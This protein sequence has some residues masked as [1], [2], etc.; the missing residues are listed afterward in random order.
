MEKGVFIT[1][2]DISKT[3]MEMHLFLLETVESGKEV[4]VA[5]VFDEFKKLIDSGRSLTISDE[6]Q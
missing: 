4:N 2:E 6:E 5:Y 1:Y 3:M